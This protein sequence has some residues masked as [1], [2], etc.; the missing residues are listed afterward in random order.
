MTTVLFGMKRLSSLYGE[1]LDLLVSLSR[2]WWT[3]WR[4][5]LASR[6]S[7]Q[8]GMR[9]LDYS[10][11]RSDIRVSIRL[12]EASLTESELTICATRIEFKMKPATYPYRIKLSSTSFN[13]VKILV[14]DPIR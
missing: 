12:E 7:L 6:P 14:I 5:S 11:S 2:L 8:R 1:S 10:S 9:L 3:P 4:S 13:V